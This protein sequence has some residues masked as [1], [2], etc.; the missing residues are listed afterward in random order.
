[1]VQR[2]KTEDV[3]V[4]LWT[5]NEDHLNVIDHDIV[6]YLCMHAAAVTSS[7]MH[8]TVIHYLLS[9]FHLAPKYFKLSCVQLSGSPLNVLHFYSNKACIW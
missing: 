6:L 9:N 4:S 5:I 3:H 7:I 1:M 2:M 8:A